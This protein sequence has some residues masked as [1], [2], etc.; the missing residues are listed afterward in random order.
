MK[1]YLKNYNEDKLKINIIQNYTRLF[2]Q[3]NQK[4]EKYYRIKKEIKNC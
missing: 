2:L 3:K 4:K 1:P